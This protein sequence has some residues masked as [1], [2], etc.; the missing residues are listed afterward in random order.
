[1]G[2]A[3]GRGRHEDS[4]GASRGGIFLPVVFLKFIFISFCQETTNV[5]SPLILLQIDRDDKIY[6]NSHSMLTYID[7]IRFF[8]KAL[9]NWHWGMTFFSQLN[10]LN[11]P[12]S[13]IIGSNPSSTSS[14]SSSASSSSGN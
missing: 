12:F 4:R 5:V 14:S 11:I 13:I 2:G 7:I 6:F 1:M 3:S 8:V 9:C 10:Q